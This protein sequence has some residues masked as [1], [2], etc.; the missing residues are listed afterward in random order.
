MRIDFQAA[1]PEAAFLRRQTPGLT[2][3]NQE[4]TGFLD[5]RFL[6]VE[7]PHSCAGFSLNPF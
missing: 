7:D 4:L 1:L 3:R 6:A 5:V 2:A